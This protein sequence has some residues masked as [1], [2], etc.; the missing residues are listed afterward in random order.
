MLLPAAPPVPWPDGA[1][2]VDVS[3]KHVPQPEPHHVA[4]PNKEVEA[5]AV[6]SPFPPLC[7]LRISASYTLASQKCLR[8]LAQGVVDRKQNFQGHH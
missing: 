5:A 2:P 3:L 4:L 6:K 7:A 1:E 8:T